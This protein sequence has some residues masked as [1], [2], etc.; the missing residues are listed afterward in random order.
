MV[1]LGAQSST[2]MHLTTLEI[3]SPQYEPPK[4]TLTSL[5]FRPMRRGPVSTGLEEVGIRLNLEIE[6]SSTLEEDE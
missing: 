3:R 4:V 6:F 1:Y 5:T 2:L